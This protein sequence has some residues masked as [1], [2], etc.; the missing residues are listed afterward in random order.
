MKENF[1]PQQA[2]CGEKKFHRHQQNVVKKNFHRYQQNA[3]KK[4]FSPLKPQISQIFTSLISTL[5]LY[6]QEISLKYVTHGVSDYEGDDTHEV[7]VRTLVLQF[8]FCK[9]S[10]ECGKKNY[11]PQNSTQFLQKFTAFSAFNAKRCGR[12]AVKKVFFSPL[13][14]AN[15][16][17]F[18]DETST[19]VIKWVIDLLWLK[20]C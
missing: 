20:W 2:G 6:S 8:L 14:T 17:L 4:N 18:F 10:G 16:K 15:L 19:R 3:V 12:F 11:S 1:S 9:N 13:F 7:E 5:I